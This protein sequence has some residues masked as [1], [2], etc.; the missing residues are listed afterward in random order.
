MFNGG[1]QESRRG[2]LSVLGADVAVTGDIVT[3]GDLHVDGTV[4]GDVRCG[5]IVQGK[6]GRIVGSIT[7]A[8]ARIAGL[9][10]GQVDAAALTVQSG[11]RIVGDL[12]YATLTIETGAQVDGRMTHRD[13]AA[14]PVAAPLADP[15]LRL[16][17]ATDPAA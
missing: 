1:K 5:S 13:G 9:V 17:D 6:T 15:P 7:A 14:E 3:A 4:T 12:V 8:T 10:E 11:A 2:G 16:V